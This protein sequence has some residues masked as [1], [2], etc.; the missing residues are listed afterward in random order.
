MA[1]QCE[2]TD[3]FGGEANYSWVRRAIIPAGKEHET[4]ASLM[5]RAKRA[6][7]LTGVR[8]RTQRQSGTGDYEFH[9]W[10]CCTVA[11]VS[12][13]DWSDEAEIVDGGKVARS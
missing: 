10:G 6:L 4:Q 8:G 7:N 9:P 11:F 13:D 5:R 2:Y 12:W 3:T 1:W